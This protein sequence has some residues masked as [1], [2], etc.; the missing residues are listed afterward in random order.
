M[1]C[2]VF[3]AFLFLFLSWGRARAEGAYEKGRLDLPFVGHTTFGK[4]PPFTDWARLNDSDAEVAVLGVPMDMGTQYRSGA[5]M[6]PRAIREASTL[7]Q[8]GHSEVYDFDTD[9]TY[10]YGKVIDVGDVDVVHTDTMT[11]HSRTQAAVETLLG[12]GKMPVILGGDHAITAPNCAAL[13]KLGR[14]I[15]L[16]Q[17]DA[18]MDFVDERHGVR[19]GHGNCMRRCL[20]MGHIVKLFQFGIRGVSSTAKSGFDDARRMG[21]TILS[22]RQVRELG[23]AKVAS[24]IPEDASVYFSI[25]IDGFD[26]SLSMG[27]GTPSHGGFLYYEVKDL[28]RHIVYRVKGGLVGMDLVEVAPP[29]DPAQVTSTLAARVVLDVIGFANKKRKGTCGQGE[30]DKCER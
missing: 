8:F 22:V 5:R 27:T 12:A 13:A 26:P 14:P 23:A 21:S 20:E 25:D 24:M 7:Y 9:E 30:D 3:N 28:L 29:Y 17:I 16:I 4:Y 19:Y 11:T 1:A 10:S 2:F 18:H 6:G 15:T